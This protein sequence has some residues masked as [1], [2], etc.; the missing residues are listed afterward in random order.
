VAWSGKTLRRKQTCGRKAVCVK[1]GSAGQMIKGPRRE[2]KWIKR[3]MAKGDMDSVCCMRV[4][5]RDAH[6]TCRL[7]R[8]RCCGSGALGARCRNWARNYASTTHKSER[9]RDVWGTSTPS[10]HDCMH[11]PGIQRQLRKPWRSLETSSGLSIR[12]VLSC[13]EE[14]R[15]ASSLR[16]QQIVLVQSAKT[17][18]QWR[19]QSLDPSA[20][21]N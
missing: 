20:V 5:T 16:E 10:S 19:R 6:G 8:R 14:L 18:G 21:R 9:L 15:E 12:S 7:V 13:D 17:D 11:H 1:L 3:L 4:D 2:P